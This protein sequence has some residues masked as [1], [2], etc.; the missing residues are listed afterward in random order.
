MNAGDARAFAGVHTAKAPPWR[1]AAAPSEKGKGVEG[2]ELLRTR[3]Q[4][5]LQLS[6]LSSEPMEVGLVS[7]GCL[8]VSL[9]I[10]GPLRS[11]PGGDPLGRF[12]FESTPG[13]FE[14]M[15]VYGAG[16]G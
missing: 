9:L 8:A 1:I 13:A 2:V 16:S 15:D 5:H 10:P 4:Q 14:V 6:G 11:S 7:T 3:E 12:R